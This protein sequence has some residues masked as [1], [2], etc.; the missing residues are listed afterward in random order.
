VACSRDWPVMAKIELA[1]CVSPGGIEM[2]IS[3]DAND[4]ISRQPTDDQVH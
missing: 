3:D 2:K 1:G 4:G